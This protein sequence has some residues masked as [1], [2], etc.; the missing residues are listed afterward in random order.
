M[1]TAVAPS[2][3]RF[4]MARETMELAPSAPTTTL[5]LN[6]TGVPSELASTRTCF[7]SQ[8]SRFT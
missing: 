7:G 8:V 3:I 1:E 4:P 2:M 6:E 5:P